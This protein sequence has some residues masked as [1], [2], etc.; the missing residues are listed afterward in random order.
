MAIDGLS[1]SSTSADLH[2]RWLDQFG[3]ENSAAPKAP[4]VL[5]YGATKTEVD[6]PDAPRMTLSPGLFKSTAP[7]PPAASVGS[8]YTE[9]PNERPKT[10]T[11]MATVDVYNSVKT[12]WP[13]V[14]NNAAKVLAAQ[15]AAET[16]GGASMKN[17][18]F[19]NV[20]S[21]AKQT[22]AYFGGT[23][24]F[25]NKMTKPGETPQQAGD[26]IVATEK[27]VTWDNGDLAKKK[28]YPGAQLLVYAP[29]H[30]SSRF[31]AFD[32]ADAGMTSFVAYHQR[33]AAKNPAYAAALEQGDARTAAQILIKAG[34]ATAPSKGYA[35]AMASRKAD[36]DK[37]VP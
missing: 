14:S 3:P 34:Y 10:P 16:G 7:A 20:K 9:N 6:L 25:A 28:G 32:S 26:R 13:G 1:S 2:A 22:H 21:G 11:P 5:H 36:L 8:L 19:G 12:H 24:E 27:G 37:V 30:A 35:D 31:A 18:N 23:W 29:P 17:W 15:S 4:N 33:L